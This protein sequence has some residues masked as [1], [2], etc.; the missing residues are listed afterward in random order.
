MVEG[1]GAVPEEVRSPATGRTGRRDGERSA[2]FNLERAWLGV[3]LAA[4]AAAH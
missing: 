2:Q 4:T 3:P 1:K